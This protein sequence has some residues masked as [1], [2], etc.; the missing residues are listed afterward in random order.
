M[1]SR[2]VGRRPLGTPRVKKSKRTRYVVGV[3]LR[4]CLRAMC[5]GCRLLRHDL[6]RRERG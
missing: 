2:H 4:A 3:T 5:R 1:K 6:T